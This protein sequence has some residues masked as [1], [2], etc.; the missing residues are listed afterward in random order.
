[1][2]SVHDLNRA[3]ALGELTRFRGHGALY[4]GINHGR[5]DF[6]RLRN[7][8]AA[9]R[10]PKAADAPHRARRGR[11]AVAASR[12]Q[13]LAGPVVLPHLPVEAATNIL[14]GTST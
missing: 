1:M 12:R 4:D 11:V 6:A 14:S 7:L 3:T 13:H 2:I 9:Q 5:V 10:L 8:L